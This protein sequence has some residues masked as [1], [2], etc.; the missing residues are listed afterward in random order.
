MY[1]L[2]E[3]LRIVALAAAAGSLLATTACGSRAPSLSADGGGTADPTRS[4][5]H[6]TAPTEPGHCSGRIEAVSVDGD[7]TV[8]DGA[9]CELVGTRVEG[10]ISVGPAARLY[11]HAV[12]VDGDIEGE[13]TLDVQVT[14]GSSVGGNLQLESGGTALV[15][16]SHIDGDLSWQDQHGAL[17]ARDSTVR[18]NLDLEDN[19]GGVTVTGNEVG[20]DLTCQD[21]S[22]A[23]Q[24][25]SNTVSGDKEDQC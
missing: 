20:G 15:T 5:A 11:A 16:D 3:P 8:P 18:G 10:N 12:A 24:A 22:P 23:P 25:G 17:V 13:R 9:T 2:I 7:V 14:E 4:A 1:R 6:V 19:T 21:N